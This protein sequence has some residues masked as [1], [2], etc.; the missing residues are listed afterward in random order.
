MTNFAVSLF[1][2]IHFEITSE[3]ALK[4]IAKEKKRK[5]WLSRTWVL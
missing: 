1:L 2:S 5:N 3:L 4:L